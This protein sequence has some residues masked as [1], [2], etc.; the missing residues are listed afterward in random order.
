MSLSP[1]ETI[2]QT[3]LKW[4]RSLTQASAV[5][6]PTAGNAEGAD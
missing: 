5:F 3:A 6:S 4:L 1:A 2:Q